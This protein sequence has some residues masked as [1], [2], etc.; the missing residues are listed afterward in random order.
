MIKQ[1]V[2]FRF[3][4]SKQSWQWVSFCDPWPIW[5]I[6]L[7]NE[8]THDPL[9]HDPLTRD[10]LTHLSSTIYYG[11]QNYKIGLKFL[12]VYLVFKSF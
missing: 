9:T 1:A 11:T 10:P 3:T 5:P 7:V 6:W 4:C 2:D 8:V 12:K